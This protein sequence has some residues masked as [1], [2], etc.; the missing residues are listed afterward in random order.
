[1][2]GK[3]IE[4]V[5]RYYARAKQSSLPQKRLANN[6]G[7]HV[8]GGVP[9]GD[10]SEVEELLNGHFAILSVYQYGS[11][12]PLKFL[13]G[14]NDD[15]TPRRTGPRGM[16]HVRVAEA[17]AVADDAAA[18][19]QA[20]ACGQP[21][22]TA[23]Y[24]G[25]DFNILESDDGIVEYEISNVAYKAKYTDGT[26][27]RNRELKKAA[28]AYFN[29][30]QQCIGR[31]YLL[32][33]YG[34]GYASELVASYARYIWI[35]GSLGYSK[36]VK[37][38][39]GDAWHLF[40]NNLDRKWFTPNSQCGAGLDI[41][42]NLQ[43]PTKAD[44][45]AWNRGGLFRMDIERTKAIFAQR[46]V[47]LT[48]VRIF[49]QSNSAGPGTTSRTCYKSLSCVEGWVRRNR[50]VRILAINGEWLEIDVDEDGKRDG[51]CLARSNGTPNF[52]ENIKLMP[53]WV[54]QN[55]SHDRNCS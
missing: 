30:L 39:Q 14:L 27:V 33:V 54:G 16:D 37:C 38:L 12:T 23:I 50:N 48:G 35:S 32:G 17:E 34:N 11:N 49:D 44:V 8:C 19:A 10:L 9:R 21:Q 3:K 47:A 29:K 1:L 28:Q 22:Q 6:I 55:A 36:T 25:L 4:V 18:D 40:Q 43:N 5:G 20:R 26:F 15:G 31:K 53:N 13:F 7:S 46:P 2:K 45:G 24:F 42:T 41:D 51:Y 52:A